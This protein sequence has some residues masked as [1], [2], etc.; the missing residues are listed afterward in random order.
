MKYE[1]AHRVLIGQLWST[2]MH[3]VFWLDNYEVRVCRS[4][5]DMLWPWGQGSNPP[6]TTITRDDV[7]ITRSIIL[8]LTE[9]WNSLEEEDEPLYH[10]D[11]F[12]VLQHWRRDCIVQNRYHHGLIKNNTL[13]LWQLFLFAY[14]F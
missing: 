7:H 12:I 4:Y 13:S 2:S 8:R 6:S 3:I 1:Y 9:G 10:N 5:S 14:S 11:S